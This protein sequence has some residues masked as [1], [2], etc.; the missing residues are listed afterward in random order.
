MENITRHLIGKNVLIRSSDSGVH[1]GTLVAVSGNNVRLENSRRLW[2]WNTGGS[3]ISLSEVAICG[4]DQ[5]TSRITMP[6]PDLIVG[7]VCEIIETHGVADG[8]I[9]GAAVAKP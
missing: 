7:G 2:E 3:G 5:N 6:L 1:H 8:T 4:I 9:Q